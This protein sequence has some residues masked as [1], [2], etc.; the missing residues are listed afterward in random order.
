MTQSEFE[1]LFATSIVD[2][3]NGLRGLLFGQFFPVKLV[4]EKFQFE[5]AGFLDQDSLRTY[6]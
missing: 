5:T 2:E 3:K 4:M 6:T 1:I